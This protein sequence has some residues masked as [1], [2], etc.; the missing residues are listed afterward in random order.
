[1]DGAPQQPA[2]GLGET[3]RELYPELEAI[4]AA[5]SAPAYVVGGAVRDALLG[6]GRGDLDLLTL[7]DAAELAASLSSHPVAAH[8]RF[9]TATVELGGHR[10][11]IARARTETYPEP[12]ALPVVAPAA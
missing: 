11:D 9:R 5:A 12:G 6:R 10:I 1:M 7:G 3:L 2:T 8:D 4:A